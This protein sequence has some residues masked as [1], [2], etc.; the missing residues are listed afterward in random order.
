MPSTVFLA[1]ASG[2]IGRP[3]TLLLC[4]AGYRVFGTTRS[5]A[6]VSALHAA[7]AEP[8]VVDV[9]DAAALAEA[10]CRAAPE[11]VIHQLTDLPPLL[12]R[13]LLAEALPRN[14]RLRSEGTKNLMAAARQAGVRRVIAQSLAWVYAPGAEPHGESDALQLDAE[15]LLGVSVRGVV[16]LERSTLSAAPIEG[17][18][19]RYGQ[20]YGPGTGGSA[21]K[22]FPPLHVDAAAWAALLALEKGS[23]GVYNIAEDNAYVSSEKAKREL[24]WYAGYRR[25]DPTRST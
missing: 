12:E 20:L 6:K 8:V 5:E 2:V 21:D 10:V 7:G 15:G 23:H 1:G 11:F 17:V 19:L 16:D 9:Y 25:D 22:V 14:A 13:S 18:V 24:G 3:L 4:E